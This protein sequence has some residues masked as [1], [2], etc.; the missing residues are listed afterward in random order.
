[1]SEACLIISLS[2]SLTHTH[3]RFRLSFLL[4]LSYLLLLSHTLTFALSSPLL[5]NCRKPCMVFDVGHTKHSCCPTNTQQAHPTFSTTPFTL[6]EAQQSEKLRVG[7]TI[8]NRCSLALPCLASCYLPSCDR[9]CANTDHHHAR[10]G[11][12]YVE[13]GNTCMLIYIDVLTCDNMSAD[14]S[15]QWIRAICAHSEWYAEFVSCAR[16]ICWICV[17][18]CIYTYRDKH[19]QVYMWLYT[20]IWICVCMYLFIYLYAYIYIYIYAY[21]NIWWYIYAYIYIYTYTNAYIFKYIYIYT[22]VNIYVN[23]HIS[24]VYI[25]IYT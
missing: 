25:Y 22:Y 11:R 20:C 6:S 21:M 15:S 8:L 24:Y 13:C 16:V 23:K 19:A 14:T 3:N 4:L 12:W 18:I 9:P 7:A 10:E 2:L 1:M 5:A 17:I